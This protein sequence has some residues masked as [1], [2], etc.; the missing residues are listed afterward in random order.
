[1]PENLENSAVATELEKVSFHSNPKERKK[2]SEVAQSCSTLCD[3]M[4]CNLPGFPVHGIFQARV[5]EWISFSMESS[6]P[7]DKTQVSCIVGR[8]FYPESQR[9]AMHKKVQTTSQL[10]SSHMLAK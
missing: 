7:R 8:H 5:L 1:M 4:D 9:K 6:R 2:E 10:L 3:P